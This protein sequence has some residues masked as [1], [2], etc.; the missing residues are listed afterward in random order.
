MTDDI[1]TGLSGPRRRL[2]DLARSHGASL[3]ALSQL[4]GRN[5][6]YLQ[7]FIRKGSPRKLEE[8]DRRTLAEFLGVAESELG[9]SAKDNSYADSLFGRKADWV[10][11]PRLALD[12]SAGPG[13]LDAS[14]EPVGAFRFSARWLR[15][16]GLDPAMLS[17]ISVAGDSMEPLLSD[18]DEIL[19]DRTPAPPRDGIYVVRLGDARMVKRVQRG[20]PGWLTLISENPHYPPLEMEVDEADL[21]GRVVWKSGR[22]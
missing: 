8:N 5:P 14:E 1:P 21:I 2:L 9:G 13:A 15:G 11:V 20:R 4:I 10:D 3:A 19:V 16:Q 6:S 18:G 17:A 12:A 22:L 7:Q